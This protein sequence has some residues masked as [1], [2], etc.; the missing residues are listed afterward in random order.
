MDYDSLTAPKG[1]PGSIANWVNYSDALLPLSDIL[2]DAQA[3][4]YDMVRLRAMYST[5]EIVLPAGEIS[6][7]LPDG[8]MD[9]VKLWD[10]Y[11]C[12][13]APLDQVSLESRRSKQSDGLWGTGSAPAAYSIFNELIQFDLAADEDITLRAAGAFR[14]AYLGPTN[15]TNW[16]TREY[17]HILRPACLAMAADFL[18]DDAKYNRYVTR[19]SGL[20]KTAQ[21]SDDMAIMGMQV[22]VY[23]AGS[24]S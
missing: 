16:L 5:V 22:D 13:L 10:Q 4:I 8:L 23:S 21:Q 3:L 14:P 24:M 7:A 9:L 15:K 1:T 18:N 2:E 11:Q 17:P 12:P 6:A 19:V 20:L